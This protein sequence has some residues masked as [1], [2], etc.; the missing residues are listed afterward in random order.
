VAQQQVKLLVQVVA[1]SKQTN[2]FACAQLLNKWLSGRNEFI[3]DFP[4][5]ASRAGHRS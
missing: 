1:G 5:G 4:I 3:G 2:G